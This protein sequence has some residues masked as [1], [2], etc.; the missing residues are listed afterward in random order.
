MKIYVLVITLL[1]PFIAFSQSIEKEIVYVLFYDNSIEKCKIEVEYSSDNDGKLDG[2]Q[3]I[4]K[5]KKDSK[6]EKIN[7]HICDE[8]FIYTEHVSTID[9]CS[10]N[11][12]NKIEP[13]NLD[14]LLNKYAKG[15][16]FKHHVFEKIYIIEKISE[17]RI[18][19]YEVYWSG[20]WTIE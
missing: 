19:K 4:K 3:I 8:T 2:Y 1:T 14:Y 7:F 15:N 13:K 12:L 10:V 16:N 5:Y 9:T 6:G 11:F 20:E 17:N 18:V